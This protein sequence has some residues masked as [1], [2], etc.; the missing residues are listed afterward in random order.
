MAIMNP[1]DEIRYLYHLVDALAAGRMRLFEGDQD[2]TAREIGHLSAE[3]AA[4]ESMLRHA[5]SGR[6]D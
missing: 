1:I 3:V 4:V 2:V 6:D 5:S